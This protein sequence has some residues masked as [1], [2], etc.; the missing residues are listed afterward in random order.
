MRRSRSLWLVALVTSLVGAAGAVVAWQSSREPVNVGVAPPAVAD[1]PETTTTT[2]TAA[3][4][5]PTIGTQPARLEDLSARQVLPPVTVRIE[6]L[7]LD[8][9][10]IPV[11]V[12]QETGEMAA[13]G[14]FSTHW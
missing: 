1:G 4:A 3:A 11:G 7:G 12:K 13:A 6:S 14:A 10:V 8:A 5:V 2:T 9:P